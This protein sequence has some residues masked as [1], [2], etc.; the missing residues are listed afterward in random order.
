MKVFTGLVTQSLALLAECCHRASPPYHRSCITSKG[1]DVGV[2]THAGVRK[3]LGCSQCGQIKITW[4]VTFHNIIVNRDNY[5]VFPPEVVISR[6]LL[7]Y[8]AFLY[9][10]E[11]IDP[12][13]TS[14]T[15]KNCKDWD[16]R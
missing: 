14:G 10:T 7:G 11:K 4:R 8:L 5:V 12:P 6:P 15:Q 2:G 13:I 16:G 9:R 1:I 3:G